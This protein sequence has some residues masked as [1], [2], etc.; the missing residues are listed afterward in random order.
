MFTNVKLLIIFQSNK[1]FRVNMRIMR[2]FLTLNGFRSHHDG[3]SKKR[4]TFASDFIIEE[5]EI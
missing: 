2:S 1:L 5:N 3:V 4:C